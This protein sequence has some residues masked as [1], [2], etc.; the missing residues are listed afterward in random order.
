[1]LNG[2]GK[3][4]LLNHSMVYKEIKIDIYKD[5]LKKKI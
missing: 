3:Y 2:K 5:Y 1:M 4:T